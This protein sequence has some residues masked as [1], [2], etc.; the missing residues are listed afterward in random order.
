MARNFVATK[1]R[2]QSAASS[3][4]ISLRIHIIQAILEGEANCASNKKTPETTVEDP[5]DKRHHQKVKPSFKEFQ[6]FV[7]KGKIPK[8]WRGKCVNCSQY[9]EEPTNFVRISV[10]ATAE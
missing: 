6:D 4:S 8:T 7:T 2:K 10:R 9:F 5:E 3:K 1:Y